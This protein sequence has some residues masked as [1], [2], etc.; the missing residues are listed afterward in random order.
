M[1]CFIR[2][3]H[4]RECWD[5]KRGGGVRA[6]APHLR[7]VHSEAGRDEGS[8]IHELHHVA[9]NG[10]VLVAGVPLLKQSDDKIIL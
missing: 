3:K 4:W 2:D 1:Q 7:R 6:A 9:G 10:A 8:L 5:L